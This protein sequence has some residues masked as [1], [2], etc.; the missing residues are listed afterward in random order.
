[1]EHPCQ[2]V[3][4]GEDMDGTS[5][6][7]DCERPARDTLLMEEAWSP[8]TNKP[9][10]STLVTCRKHTREMVNDVRAGIQPPDFTIVRVIRD[11]V[12][13]S[14]P[15]DPYYSQMMREGGEVE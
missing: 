7:W 10:L 9:F 5:I 6:H 1:M 15:W 8:C 13:P 14:S 4:G 2:A 11:R 12:E 3:M